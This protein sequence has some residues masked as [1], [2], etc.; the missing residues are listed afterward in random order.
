MFITIKDNK[1]KALEKKCNE[2]LRKLEELEDGVQM[3][4][5]LGSSTAN[6]D[7]W[8]NED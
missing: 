7:D 4:K 2:A 3:A 8:I 5:P 6:V 1:R